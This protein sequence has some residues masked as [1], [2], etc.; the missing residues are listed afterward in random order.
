MPEYEWSCRGQSENHFEKARG[1]RHC[2]I[3][4]RVRGSVLSL[5]TGDFD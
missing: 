2:C 4:D 5:A 1:C 3:A